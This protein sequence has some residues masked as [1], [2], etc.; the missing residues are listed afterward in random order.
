MEIRELQ[1]NDIEEFQKIIKEFYN[2]AGDTIPQE[3]EIQILFNNAINEESNL[4]FIGAFDNNSIM[5]ILSLTFGE[6]SYKVAPFAWCD[7]FYVDKTH[8]NKGIGKSLLQKAKEIAKNKKCSNILA[9]VGKDEIETQKFYNAT[10]F[11]D[12]QCKLMTLPIFTDSLL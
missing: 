6:S 10:G 1:K 12:M 7:D 9:G 3:E 4:I 5:G 11:L 8:R 2:Y